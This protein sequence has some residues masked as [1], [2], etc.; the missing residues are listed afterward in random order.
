MAQTHFDDGVKYNTMLY[1]TRL[2]LKQVINSQVIRLII[3]PPHTQHKTMQCKPT[4]KV[5]DPF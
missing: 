3:T 4:L 1:P 5:Y 2:E